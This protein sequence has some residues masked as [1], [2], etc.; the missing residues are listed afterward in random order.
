MNNLIKV[1]F[2]FL[3]SFT[4]FSCINKEH[5]LENATDQWLGRYIKFPKTIKYTTLSTDSAN[6]DLIKKK[7]KIL[8]YA[9]SVGCTSCKLNLSGWKL[10]IEDVERLYPNQVGFVF[11]INSM[12]SIT[13]NLMLKY[14][15][16]NYPIII[17]EE[18][19]IGN[20]N[21]ISKEIHLHFFLLNHN[22]KIFL[23]GDPVSDMNVK[24][25]YIK[26]IEDILNETELN[27]DFSINNYSLKR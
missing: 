7:C 12:D 25:M 19:T 15:E 4:L 3:F 18:N 6:I 1:V 20:L 2:L 26:T 21:N 13:I 23:V 8:V 11:F 10:L 22:N 5:N 24:K 9:D 17:S 14:H 27:S 16:F